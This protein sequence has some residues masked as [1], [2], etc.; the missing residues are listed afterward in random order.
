MPIFHICTY[1]AQQ[2]IAFILINFMFYFP[3]CLE[4]ICPYPSTT[5]LASSAT[6]KN[7]ATTQESSIGVRLPSFF[8]SP[9]SSTVL[10][11]KIPPFISC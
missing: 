8:P 1:Y 10:H 3:P 4:G 6:P 7:R 9:H 2:V 11:T 5:S